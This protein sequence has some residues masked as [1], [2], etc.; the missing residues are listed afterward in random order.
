M[1][2]VWDE[3]PSMRKVSPWIIDQMRQLLQ[4]AGGYGMKVVFVLFE[5]YDTYPA[6]GSR[7]E[8]SNLAYLD[9]IVGAFANDDRVLAW[10]LHNEPDKYGGWQGGDRDEVI[11]WLRRMAVHTRRIDRQH[12][13]TVGAGDYASL[14]TPASDGTTILSFVDIASFHC[15]DAGRVQEQIRE[16]ERHTTKPV[17]LE[18]MGWPTAGGDE[19]PPANATFDEATQ[20]YLYTTMLAAA[21][22]EDIAGV[23]Q[24]VLWD[25]T[26][27]STTGGRRSSY[28]EFFGLIRTDGTLKPAAGIF[29]NDYSARAL[30]STTGTGTPLTPAGKR[31]KQP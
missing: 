31:N 21:N 12:P 11:D 5:W 7:E 2:V 19:P 22:E 23:A 18:E 25:Y 24:W 1:D 15:Y 16:T 4:I 30:P 20:A 6:E 3:D 27:R 13:I 17:F 9:G 10:D 8:R 14:W 28:E 29:K 26:P